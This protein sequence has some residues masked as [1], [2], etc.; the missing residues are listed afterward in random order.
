MGAQEFK[1]LKPLPA[2][3]VEL[4]AIA[5]QLWQG[6]SFLNEEFTL[7]NLRQARRQQG[8]GILHLATHADFRPGVSSYIQLWQDQQLTLKQLKALKLGQDPPVELLVLSA[9]RTAFGDLESE[10]GFA[11]LAVLAGVKSALGSLWY[12]S[13]E[14][15]LALMTAFYDQLRRT[16]VKAEALRQAQLAMLRGDVRLENGQLITPSEQFP[17]TPT[18]A[19]RGN[20]DLSHPF[21]GSAFTIVGNPW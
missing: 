3:P 4:S 1:L 2:V 16:P 9:C 13:D 21:F 5:D 20:R 12:V 11:G 7:G 6:R 8:F 15:T 10:L 17:L 14:G 19:S 18:L